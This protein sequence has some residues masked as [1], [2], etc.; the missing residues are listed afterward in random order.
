MPGT[1]TEEEE[2][3]DNVRIWESES[4]PDFN[5]TLT[6]VVLTREEKE[7]R[8]QQGKNKDLKSQYIGPYCKMLYT[9]LVKTD[10]IHSFLISLGKNKDWSQ[11]TIHLT[12]L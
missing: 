2:D 4:E 6:S 3:D 9:L 5:P 10:K 12:I 11:I 8:K 7:H 1:T